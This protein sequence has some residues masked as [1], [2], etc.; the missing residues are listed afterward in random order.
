MN[1]KM[2]NKVIAVVVAMFVFFAFGASANAQSTA[3]ATLNATVNPGG[4]QTTAWFEYSTSPSLTSYNQTPR[5]SVGSRNYSAPF[6]QE[7]SGLVRNTKYYFRVVTNNGIST[8]RGNI[9]SFDTYDEVVNTTNTNTQVVN[10][11]QY[12]AQPVQTIQ[13]VQP[14]VVGYQPIVAYQPVQTMQVASVPVATQQ[15]GTIQLPAHNYQNTVP[16]STVNTGNVLNT[17]ENTNSNTRY[18]AAPIYSGNFLPETVFGWLI[19][20]LIIIGVVWVVR[21]LTSNA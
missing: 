4:R 20:I 6:S 11:Y 12:V 16:L 9:L 15:T 2:K 18:A 17:V 10:Q 5:V 1:K 21:R 19:L 7:V 14:V 3:N 8:K 13:T